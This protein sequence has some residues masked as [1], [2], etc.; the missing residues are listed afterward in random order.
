MRV[1]ERAEDRIL[2]AISELKTQMANDRTM[3][4]QER[5][6]LWEKWADH[7]ER[8]K[9][10]EEDDMIAS[11][12]KRDVA[13][14]ASSLFGGTRGIITTMA[15]GTALIIGIIALTHGA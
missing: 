15:A 13:R 6:K 10:I 3:A 9:A 5:D 12:R 2:E 8:I 14:V 1:F 7:E 4:I 11:T